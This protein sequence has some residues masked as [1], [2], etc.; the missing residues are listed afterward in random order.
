MAA[1]SISMTRTAGGASLA[2]SIASC[3]TVAVIDGG[4]GWPYRARPATNTERTPAS[5]CVESIS[6]AVGASITAA[7]GVQSATAGREPVAFR[8]RWQ[9]HRHRAGLHRSQVRGCELDRILECNHHAVVPSH[10]GPPK[11][12]GKAVC[13]TVELTIGGDTPAVD[14]CRSVRPTGRG[15]LEE[16]VHQHHAIHRR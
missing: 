15:V 10:P 13:Q 3:S 4:N 6:R 11:D 14:E 12:V 1:R 16:P 9:R 2:A 7:T 8:S 5:G